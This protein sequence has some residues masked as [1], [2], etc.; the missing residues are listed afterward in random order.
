MIKI[1]IDL[2]TCIYLSISVIIL[3]LWLFWERRKITKKESNNNFWK[4]P[5]CFFEYIDSRNEE[6]SRCPRCKTLFK[7]GE[8]W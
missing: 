2:G 6:M 5:L 4:C 8:K 7:K 3:F 1:P